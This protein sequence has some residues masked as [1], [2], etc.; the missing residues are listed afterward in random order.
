M[1][2]AVMDV[3]FQDGWGAVPFTNQIADVEGKIEATL[4]EIAKARAVI[5]QRSLQ[6]GESE[7][8]I[9]CCRSRRSSSCPEP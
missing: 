2:P 1:V 9:G 8:P 3:R 5:D 7:V 6:R 4:A